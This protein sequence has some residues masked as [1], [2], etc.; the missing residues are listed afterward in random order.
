MRWNRVSRRRVLQLM[1]VAAAVTELQATET[2]LKATEDIG[3]GPFYKAG[4]P[5]RHSLREPGMEGEKLRLTGKVLDLRGKPIPG[6]RVEIWHVNT[7][8]EYDNDG[9]RLRGQ[10]AVNAKGEYWFETFAPVAYSSRCAHVHTR[11]TAPGAKTL[12]TEIQFA[13]DPKGVGGKGGW[14]K[15]LAMKT[16]TSGDQKL[17]TFV[18]V[19]RPA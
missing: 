18:F 2:D 12:A 15:S 5:E 9:F 1:G 6:A 13:D 8:G 16:E 14:R 11:V 17:G 7:K 4:S 19:L 3:P 10:V